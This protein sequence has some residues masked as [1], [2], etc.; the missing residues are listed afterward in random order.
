MTIVNDI[1]NTFTPSAI[2]TA[3]SIATTIGS[4]STTVSAASVAASVVNKNMIAGNFTMFLQL[5]T[6]QLKNQNP[7]DPLDTNQFTQ[8]LVQFAQVEQQLKANDQL[9]TLVSL[10]QMQQTTEAMSFV[11]K[12][13][14]VDGATTQLVNGQAQWSFTAPKPSNATIAISDSNG[15]QVYSGA[16][17]MQAGTQNFVWD[18]RGNDGTK[19]PDGAYT[20]SVTAKDASGQSVAVSTEILGIVDSADLTQNPPILTVG[21]Q[22]FTLDKIKRVTRTI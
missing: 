16:Y 20:I 17:T 9:A 7:L 19:K 5:L 12:T 10:Q 18:G 13:V 21:G 8:Q 1:I 22:N 6:T 2:S 14:A 4:P 15:Q 3:N 11:G